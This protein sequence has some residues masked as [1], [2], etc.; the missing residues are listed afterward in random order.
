M[1]VLKRRLWLAIL[2]LYL[3]LA[4]AQKDIQLNLQNADLRE[5]ITTV[6]KVTGKN[7][8]I[9]PSVRGSVTLISPEKLDKQ[10]LY[11]IF[12]NVLSVNGFS[13]VRGS[14]GVVR[15]VPVKGEHQFIGYE[16][17]TEIYRLKRT[18]SSQVLPIMKPLLPPGTYLSADKS[19]NLLI[20]SGQSADV[21]RAIALIDRIDKD[22]SKSFSV[23][24]LRNASAVDIARTVNHIMS[25]AVK[26]LV[27]VAADVRTNSVLFEAPKQEKLK[28]RALIAHLDTPLEHAGDTEVIYLKNANAADIAKTLQAAKRSLSHTAEK[29]TSVKHSQQISASP[30]AHQPVD[31]RADVATNALIITAPPATMRNLKQVIAK[32]DIRRAQ[33]LVEAIIAEVADSDLKNLGVQWYAAGSSGTI[34]VGV[35]NFDNASS[36]ILGI[37]TDYYRLVRSKQGSISVPKAIGSGA[38]FGIGNDNLGVLFNALNQLSGSTILAT[39]SLLAMDNHKAEFL[40]GQNIPFVTGSYKTNA[41]SS[42]NPFQTIKREDVGIKLNIQPRITADNNIALDIYQEVSNVV[43]SADEKLG[44]TT[45]KR[46]LKTAVLVHDEQILVLGGAIQTE[47]IKKKQ[48]VPVLGDV[49]LLGGLFRSTANT[50][51]KSNLMIFIRPHILR[52]R[53][54]ADFVTQDKYDSIRDTQIVNNLS[55]DATLPA[56]DLTQQASGSRTVDEVQQALPPVY[57]RGRP[58]LRKY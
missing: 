27:K 33:V 46:S 34:P 49:P 54:S 38:T 19:S 57:E 29:A 6:S 8:V 1:K 45:A 40:V 7:F 32:L 17:I 53:H 42:S 47:Q 23:I 55:S 25:G 5:F 48:K 11:S 35:V 4:L 2:W 36:S 41:D 13:A 31:I 3:P 28:I 15:I 26:D 58:A 16:G 22:D 21:A 30:E 52:D 20:L 39:P 50:T 10:S 37:A 14:G 56:I 51:T 12:L 24:R 18:Q 9:G 43:P 44:P